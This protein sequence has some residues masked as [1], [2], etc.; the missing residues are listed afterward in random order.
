MRRL[1]GAWR[2]ARNHAAS[3]RFG[4]NISAAPGVRAVLREQTMETSAIRRQHE[5]LA[6]AAFL[7]ALSFRLAI[8]IKCAMPSGIAIQHNRQRPVFNQT[9]NMS[10]IS[11]AGIG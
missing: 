9:F 6:A 11:S 5:M 2:A 7:C 4:A 10:A 8:S 3:S 1:T